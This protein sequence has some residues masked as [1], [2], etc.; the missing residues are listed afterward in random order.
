MGWKGARAE[1]GG[2]MAH[3]ICKGTAANS[4]QTFLPLFA[5]GEADRSKVEANSSWIVTHETTCISQ[6]SNAL[7]FL[8]YLPQ[9][10][11][12]S[13][14]RGSLSTAANFTCRCSNLSANAPIVQAIEKE[15]GA[16][17]FLIGPSSDLS[18]QHSSIRRIPDLQMGATL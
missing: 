13:Y 14:Q 5:C 15:F 2:G 16:K 8:Q 3:R 11:F 12:V 10:S 9:Y 18:L 1:G 4:P 6:K 17:S 7:H